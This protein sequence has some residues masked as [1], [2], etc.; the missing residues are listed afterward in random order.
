VITLGAESTSLYNE[1]LPIVEE[2]LSNPSTADTS[3]SAAVEGI[4][5]AC[6]IGSEN[7]DS[8]EKCLST[9]QKLFSHKATRVL[10]SPIRSWN[11]LSTTVS[12]EYVHDTLLPS[13]LFDLV[14]LLKNEDVDVR[15]EAGEAIAL[16][17]E[18]A[19]DVDQ[20]DFDI[21]SLS[22]YI[23]V[24]ELFDRLNELSSDKT[25]GRSRKERLKQRLPFKEIAAAVE[26]G[27][28]PTETLTFLRQKVVFESW[29]Q[30]TQ[31]NAFRDVLG[32][33]LQVHYENN[34]LLNEIFGSS[35]SKTRKATKLSG[36][37]KRLLLSPFS[38]VSK[39]RSR[40]RTSQRSQRSATKNLSISEDFE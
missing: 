10:E 22:A 4:A 25:K 40:D 20:D 11:L 3:L 30:I 17:V 1:I 16:L 19:R 23:D 29:S 5:F 7:D 39:A 6:F 14:E 15:V 24:N 8:T 26:E 13:A 12:E 9:F 2:I 37:E 38:S 21:D 36:L 34:S 18:I 28:V 33:G 35:V 31:L 27:I 32:Q